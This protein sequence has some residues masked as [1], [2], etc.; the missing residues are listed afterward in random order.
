MF[1]IE[2]LRDAITEQEVVKMTVD[3]LRR[4]AIHYFERL[5]GSLPKGLDTV[6]MQGVII[7][8]DEMVLMNDDLN[9][10]LGRL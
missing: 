3:H 7:W 10:K 4:N 2:I 1:E 6:C 8:I 5:L 9:K